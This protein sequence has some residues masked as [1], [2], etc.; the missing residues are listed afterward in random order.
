MKPLQRRPRLLSAL[1]AVSIVAG[2]Y[3]CFELG[4]IQAG[5]SLLDHDRDFDRL[6]KTAATQRADLEDAQE[7]L[8]M[9]K[10]AR[11]V[12]RET[13]ARVEASLSQLQAKLQAQ[14]EELEFYRGIVSPNSGQL[15]LRVQSLQ[16]RP[17]GAEGH[18]VLQMVLT[19]AIVHN[20]SVEGVVKLKIA[21]TRRGQ[22][23]EL[24]LEDVAGDDTKELAYAFRYFQ[25][26]E[27]ELELPEG[28]VPSTLD[29]EI[30]PSSPRGKPT[31]Q[32]FQWSAVVAE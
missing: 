5:Y 31:T 29:V 27:Q 28:F 2:A 17:D 23:A 6:S 26:L 24:A 13:Y 1:A 10:T 22:P 25:A 4:R 20:R 7:Q 32:E 11:E 14:E 3:L 16:I 12:D 9:L 21:G 30:A 19:Q 8:A 18:Y 15:G